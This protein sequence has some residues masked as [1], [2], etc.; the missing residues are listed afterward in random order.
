[1]ILKVT[2][3]RGKTDDGLGE[4]GIPKEVESQNRKQFAIVLLQSVKGKLFFSA[5]ARHLTDHLMMNSY[6]LK[7]RSRKEGF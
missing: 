5:V 4:G 1:M 2:W 3:W 6:F 7:A